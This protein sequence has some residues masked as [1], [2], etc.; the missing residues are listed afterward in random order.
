[1]NNYASGKQQFAN[2]NKNNTT[3]DENSEI[4]SYI[5][6]KDEEGGTRSRR[7]EDRLV[8]KG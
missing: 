2:N 1:M 5:D 6:L 3:V 4:R 8:R 7:N